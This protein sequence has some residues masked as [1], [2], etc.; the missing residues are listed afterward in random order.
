MLRTWPQAVLWGCLC[1]IVFFFWPGHGK[2]V[3]GRNLRATAA[4][5]F[6]SMLGRDGIQGTVCTRY[7]IYILVEMGI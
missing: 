1:S 5:V 6:S 3:V 7:S 4:Y 2:R